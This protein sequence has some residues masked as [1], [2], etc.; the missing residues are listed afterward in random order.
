MKRVLIPVD[1]SECSLRAVALVI[2]KR[3]RYAQPD[4]LEIHLVNV[5]APLLRDISRFASH[6]Q[7]ATFHRDESEKHLQTAR[8]LLDDAEAKYEAHYLVGPIAESISDLASSLACDQIVI[9]TH[10][11]GALTDFLLGS[12]THKVVH[13]AKI[14][15]LLVK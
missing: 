13:L 14:P 15:V 7:I 2:S 5:Q 6:E 1:G 12:I 8:R 11:R 4:D 9:G 3:A 10:G